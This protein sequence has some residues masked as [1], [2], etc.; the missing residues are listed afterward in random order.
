MSTGFGTANI[1]W[2]PEGQVLRFIDL[3]HWVEW[4]L[5]LEKWRVALA[6]SGVEF[7]RQQAGEGFK[8]C[9]VRFKG[10]PEALSQVDHAEQFV[11]SLSESLEAPPEDVA[12]LSLP[13]GPLAAL[14]VRVSDAPL[15][16]FFEEDYRPAPAAAES[17]A[18]LPAVG[19]LALPACD[20]LEIPL[21]LEAEGNFSLLTPSVD[22]VAEY[23][24]PV[25]CI[26]PILDEFCGHMG[27]SNQG[28]MVNLR[29]DARIS[30][31]NPIA[32]ALCRLEPGGGYATLYLHFR[33]PT[34]PTVSVPVLPAQ[35][36]RIEASLAEQGF[37][38]VT[39]VGPN[40]IWRRGDD[41]VHCLWAARGLESEDVP[42]LPPFIAVAQAGGSRDPRQREALLTTILQAAFGRLSKGRR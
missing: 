31:E 38:R 13:N 5:D 24:L 1:C 10:D 16:S 20:A 18:R 36:A 33:T 21:L 3:H 11:A 6:S 9:R 17:L 37:A 42:M 7:L 40:Q 8:L 2:V 4:R 39:R 28:K 34:E 32:T 26:P 27:N 29:L 12:D 25:D 19:A 14:W 22:C 30:A 15:E 41:W 23:P 35:A